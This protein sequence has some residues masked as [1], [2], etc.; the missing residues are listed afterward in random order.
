MGAERIKI[1]FSELDRVSDNRK[2]SFAPTGVSFSTADG[3]GQRVFDAAEMTEKG[4]RFPKVTEERFRN[5]LY[6]GCGLNPS[7]WAGICTP[8]DARRLHGTIRTSSST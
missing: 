8:T 4:G 1:P 6:A 7:R 3:K 2:M 5:Y